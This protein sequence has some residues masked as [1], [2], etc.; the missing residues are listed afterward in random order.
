MLDRLKEKWNIKS[1]WSLVAILIVFSLA[2][3]S[4]MFVKPLWYNLFG[5]DEDTPTWL[6]ITIWII[7]VFP[8]YQIFLLIYGFL[9]GQFSFFWRKEKAM[10]RAIAKPF[11][12]RKVEDEDTNE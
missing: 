9:F 1:N 7:M 12:P 10:F 3:S 2:G 8:T 6:R 11:Q 4:I 5:I